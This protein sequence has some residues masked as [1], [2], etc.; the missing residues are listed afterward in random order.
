MDSPSPPV[1][2]GAAKLRHRLD[3]LA[4]FVVVLCASYVA[5]LVWVDNGNGT[6]S[7][8][9]DVWHLMLLAIVPVSLTYLF[10]Y[11]RWQWL[12]RRKGH[13]VPMGLGLAGYLAGFALTATPGKAGELMRIRYFARMGIPA[14]RTLGVFV[15]ERAS[16]LLVILSLSLLAAS[17][18][19]TLGALAAVVL[20]FVCVLF[21]AAA[22]PALLDNLA[23]LT[24]R[25][26]GRWLRRLTHFCLAAA[27]ELRSCLDLPAFG[28]SMLAGF[29]AL[30]LTS[31]VFVSLC[32]GMGLHLGL[33]VAFGI[34]PLA[35]LIGALSFVPGGVGTTELAIVLMLNRLG[36]STA[37]AIAVAVAVRV[38]TLWYAI[39]VGAV[40]LLAAELAI[41]KSP[42]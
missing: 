20:G 17:V 2:N 3:Y 33:I 8:L 14:E 15:F 13:R 7:R 11:W 24:A 18:F 4:A 42:R 34:Y 27:L 25:L 9:K 35:M 28:Q 36:I 16:D 1:I 26:P 19:P 40:S 22:W 38:V 23:G 5:V 12:L 10:R 32:V 21:G 37:D 39:L 41:R 29:I 30:G 31:A 6:F